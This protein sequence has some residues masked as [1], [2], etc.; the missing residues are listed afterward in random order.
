MD[1]LD[2]L[3]IPNGFF[4]VR[5]KRTYN[6]RIPSCKPYINAWIGV[7]VEHTRAKRQSSPRNSHEVD[8]W[9]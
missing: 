1:F 7:I 8:L 2:H 4:L 9:N 3:F 5:G 6:Q